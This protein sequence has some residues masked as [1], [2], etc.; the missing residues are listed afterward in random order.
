MSAPRILALQRGL[1]TRRALGLVALWVPWLIVAGALAG[2]I[3]GTRVA[4]VALFVGAV[5]IGAVV[6]WDA[7]RIAHR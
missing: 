2:R 6:A 3:F 1:R 7:R 4:L 5:A